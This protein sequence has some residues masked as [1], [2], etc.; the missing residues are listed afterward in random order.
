M[1]DETVEQDT[2][3]EKPHTPESSFLKQVVEQLASKEFDTLHGVIGPFFVPQEIPPDT[4]SPSSPLAQE[5]PPTIQLALDK[6]TPKYQIIAGKVH[7]VSS[8]KSRPSTPS[9]LVSLPP[10]P[11]GSSTPHVPIIRPPVAKAH[12]PESIKKFVECGDMADHQM[13]E[14]LGREEPH[15]AAHRPAPMFFGATRKRP[16]EDSSGE[17]SQFRY[18]RTNPI[19]QPSIREE[20]F[21]PFGRE[22]EINLRKLKEDHAPLLEYYDSD[23]ITSFLSSPPHCFCLKPCARFD[24]IV[25]VYV[26]GAL[27]NLYTPSD[28]PQKAESH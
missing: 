24:G 4:D 26:C 1:V 9:S 3:T 25:P 27:R 13:V 18:G 21:D 11:S 14:T 19:N 23:A 20:K 2:P 10:T 7:K 15:G 28:I 17:S 5:L 8:L 12:P 6:E 16:L 22:S